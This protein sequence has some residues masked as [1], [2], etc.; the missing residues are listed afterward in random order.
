MPVRVRAER[1]RRDLGV[2]K[3][4]G[5]VLAALQ[6]GNDHRALRFALRRFVQAV[7]HALRFDE[8]ERVERVLPRRLEVRRLIEP[9]VAVP[10]APEPLDDTIHLVARDVLGPLE[11]HVLDPVRHAG[12]ARQFVARPDAVPAPHRHKRSR[13]KCLREDFEAVVEVG[14]AHFSH[15]MGRIRLARALQPTHRTAVIYGGN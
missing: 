4:I 13:V 10:R 11:I 7:G 2:E 6:L 5:I 1:R 8:Q 3:L 14:R 9:R 15:Y 12:P